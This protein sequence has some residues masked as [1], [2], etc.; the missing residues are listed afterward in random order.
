[1]FS[2]DVQSLIRSMSIMVL[3]ISA[4]AALDRVLLQKMQTV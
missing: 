3:F 1:M 2:I 4:F